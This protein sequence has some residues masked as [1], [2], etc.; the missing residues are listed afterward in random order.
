[1]TTQDLKLKKI[2]AIF[3]DIDDTLFPTTKWAKTA[4]EYA[5]Q[6]I[7]DLNLHK[8]ITKEEAI[9]IVEEVGAE[10]TY[11]YRFLFYNFLN[12][13]LYE[14]GIK[15]T[16]IDNALYVAAAQIEYEKHMVSFMDSYN[17]VLDVF[18]RLDPHFILGVV[19]DYDIESQAY[20]ICKLKLHH[21]LK[22]KYM[23]ISYMMGV[24]KQTSKI[25]TIACKRSGLKPQECA[26][27]GDDPEMDIKPANEAGWLTFLIRREG[28]KNRNKECPVQPD[29]TIYDLFELL[30]K[31]S[32][33]R[34]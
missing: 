26:Y 34:R 24:T 22:P 12:R 28:T 7:L 9:E 1:M 23:F 30:E 20:K 6:A 5:V 31:L 2:K 33:K 14:K 21:F 13:I 8:H 15:L 27:V 17:D 32:I 29:Y 4:R 18:T 10:F 11:N 16:D 19:T 3:F 25:F